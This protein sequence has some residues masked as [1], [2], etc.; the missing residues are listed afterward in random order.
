MRRLSPA[1]PQLTVALDCSKS[2]LL[3]GLIFLSSCA[4]Q[5]PL[6]DGNSVGSDVSAAKANAEVSS[7]QRESL[8]TPPSPAA[9]VQFKLYPAFLFL[10][11]TTAEQITFLESTHTKQSIHI[12]DL[13]GRENPCA[14][15]AEFKEKAAAVAAVLG[16][17]AIVIRDGTSGH[18]PTKEPTSGPGFAADL[19]LVPK[20]RLGIQ[21]E[22]GRWQR[23]EPSI[24]GFDASSLGP[25]GG[26]RVG[27]RIVAINGVEVLRQ[28]RFTQCWLAWAVGENVVIAFVREGVPM[29]TQVTTIAN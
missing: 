3:L 8:P 26:L 17:Q 1:H 9:P 4:T 5:Q 6:S 18:G 13:S 16:G 22:G 2:L 29:T 15:L 21:D 10:P 24:E 7:R 20:A 28:D 19:L 14:T 27:D 23:K 12:G 25:T 11:R